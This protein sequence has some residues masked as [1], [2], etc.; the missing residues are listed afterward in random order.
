MSFKTFLEI[1]SLWTAAESSN[2]PRCSKN[3]CVSFLDS[4]SWNVELNLLVLR[5]VVERLP[6]SLVAAARSSPALVA[7]K[8][9]YQLSQE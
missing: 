9:D 6:S 1:R 3:F 4:F 7:L 8:Q 2:P 5:A